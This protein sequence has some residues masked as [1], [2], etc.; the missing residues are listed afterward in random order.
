M[1][2]LHMQPMKEVAF[3]RQSRV[4]FRKPHSV[5]KIVFPCLYFRSFETELLLVP[6]I[7]SLTPNYVK[8]KSKVIQLSGIRLILNKNCIWRGIQV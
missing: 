2:P 4:P 1:C 8:L 3:V 7:P 6:T 5:R